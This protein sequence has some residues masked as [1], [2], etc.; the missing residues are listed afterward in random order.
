MDLNPHRVRSAEFKTAKRGLDPDE[1]RQFLGEVA[2]ALE[3]AQN[4]STAMEAR[5]RAAV[6]R[7]QELSD[8]ASSQATAARSDDVAAASV[9]QAE[10]ISRTL[11]LA[12]RT[13]DT[14]IAQAEAESQRIVAAA[15][16]EA[17]ATLD[18]T[19]EM[20][21]RLMGEARDEARRAGEAERVAIASEVDSLKARRDFLESDVDQLEQFLSAQRGR[22]RDAAESMLELSERVDGG[23]GEVRRPLLSAAD[24]TASAGAGG[25]S[26]SEAPTAEALFDA[27]AAAAGGDTVVDQTADT[28]AD[29]TADTVVDQTGDTVADQ[30]GEH[31]VEHVDD[32]LDAAAAPSTT[33]SEIGEFAPAAGGAD[34]EE[35]PLGFELDDTGDPERPATDEDVRFSFD[36]RI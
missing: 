23:V 25:P 1:V 21:A 27:S 4:Q 26:E 24:D 2:D 14:T 20:A 32:P 11:L 19:R 28:V 30:T 10:T 29:Q 12:Q 31:H 8:D 17:A 35:T 34:D 36:D 33:D 18:S 13:A 7:L 22:L 3:T 15:T 9:E 16:D 5:A 6:A